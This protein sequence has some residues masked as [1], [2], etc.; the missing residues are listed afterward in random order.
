MIPKPVKKFKL[1]EDLRIKY[2]HDW[3]KLFEEI[4]PRIKAFINE[5]E[6]VYNNPDFYKIFEEKTS[7]VFYWAPQFINPRIIV[8]F[9]L[10]EG[11]QYKYLIGFNYDGM[12][13]DWEFRQDLSTMQENNI[14]ECSP[15]TIT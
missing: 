10:R 8:E 6:E 12:F 15:K 7:D 9:P 13:S 2:L 5:S 3:K 4:D 1:K 14:E 11:F